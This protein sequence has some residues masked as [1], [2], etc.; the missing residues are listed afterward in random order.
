MMGDRAHGR[1]VRRFTRRRSCGAFSFHLTRPEALG[2]ASATRHSRKGPTLGRRLP[3]RA[4][5]DAPETAA[6][7]PG[8]EGLVAGE[9]SPQRGAGPL[10]EVSQR[11]HQLGRHAGKSVL[12][13]R[14]NERAATSVHGPFD[15]HRPRRRVPRNPRRPG[16]RN[17]RQ[18]VREGDLERAPP[19]VGVEGLGLAKDG[20]EG[21]RK[22]RPQYR[23]PHGRGCSRVL[24]S[25]DLSTRAVG[26]A[27]P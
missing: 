9:R 10:F 16:S 6:L 7:G 19:G 26:G 23:P 20:V 17:L 4:D 2:P 11:F 1:S 14:E 12:V 25:S 27:Y 15:G 24:S 5:A 21:H 3:G 13:W 8:G 18:H 22:L